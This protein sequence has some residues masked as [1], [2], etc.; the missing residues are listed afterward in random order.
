MYFALDAFSHFIWGFEK[1]VLVLT[2]NRSLTSFFETKEI[3]PSLWNFLDRV[4]AYNITLAHVPGHA[5][6]A[7][8]FLSRM[9]TEPGATLQLGITDSLPVREIKVSMATRTPDILINELQFNNK[10]L[11]E[12]SSCRM[13]IFDIIAGIKEKF[14]EL[15]NFIRENESMCDWEYTSLTR[16]ENN[17]LHEPYPLNDSEISEHSTTLNLKAEQ[18]KDPALRKV[19]KGIEENLDIDIAYETHEIKK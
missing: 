8:D 13:R 2:D 6:A 3:H 19:R 9:E 7:S 11:E 14:P 12:N 5:N 4:L 17:A 16:A 15:A 1:P 18:S 10:C